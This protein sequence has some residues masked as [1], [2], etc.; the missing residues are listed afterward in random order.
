MIHRD[1]DAYYQWVTFWLIMVLFSFL[2]PLLAVALHPLIK[3]VCF[4]WLTLPRYQ[5]AMTIYAVTV[6]PLFDKYESRL[7]GQVDF[8][9]SQLKGLILQILTETGWSIFL[10][11]MVVAHRI[12]RNINRKTDEVQRTVP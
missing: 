11:I 8:A 2:E 1:V 12:R 7:E 9:K 4:L 10:H 5:A 6:R 3:L